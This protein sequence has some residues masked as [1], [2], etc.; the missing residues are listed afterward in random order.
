[1]RDD[2]HNARKS[3]GRA[4]KGLP[5][6]RPFAEERPVEDQNDHGHRRHNQRGDAGRDALLRPDHEA[7]ADAGQ[8]HAAQRSDA[9]IDAGERPGI[10]PPQ[11]RVHRCAGQQKARARRE[12]KGGRVWIAIAIAR[13]VVPQMM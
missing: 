7:V 11:P 4:E 5:R 13:Y 2:G 1:M 12:M 8:Q 6:R 9:E 10:S 3:D